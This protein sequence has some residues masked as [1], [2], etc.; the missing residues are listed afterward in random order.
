M[1]KNNTYIFIFLLGAFLNLIAQPKFGEISFIEIDAITSK[2]AISCIVQDEDGII[3]IGTYGSGIYRFDGINYIPYEHDFSDNPSINGNIIHQI[4]IDKNKRLWVGTNSGLNLYNKNLDRFE[5][6]DMKSDFFIPDHF[7]A[8][9][10]IQDSF[11][12]LLVSTYGNGILKIDIETL[13]VTK[14]SST[15]EKL[16]TILVNT[17][18][19]N[20]KGKVLAGTNSGLFEFDNKSNNL[21]RS[22]MNIKGIH[23]HSITI[24]SLLIDNKDNLWIGTHKNG[25]VKMSYTDGVAKGKRFPW[26]N[27]KVFSMITFENQILAGTENDGLLVL[28]QEKG[29]LTQNY[30]HDELNPKSIG[31][32]SIWSLCI[33]DKGRIWLGY[34][35]KGVAVF[36]KNY[37][38]FKSFEGEV[39]NK[40]SI[41]K[42]S[43]SG[44]AKDNRGRLWISLQD[45]L[46]IYDPNTG[47]FHHIR[48]D[49]NKEYT[50]LNGKLNLQRI[51]I[52]SKQN[53]WLA[54]WENGLY[55]LK[56]D[57]KEF[58]NFNIKNTDGIL[59]TN[60]I[61]DFS[62]DSQG[63]IWIASF[64]H[65]IYRYDPITEKLTRCDSEPFITSRLSTSDVLSIMVDQEDNI[66][67]GT[68]SGLFK[69]RYQTQ[70]NDFIVINMSDKMPKEA[71]DH[72]SIHRISFLYQSEDGTIWVGTKA[73][74][75][76]M[77][78]KEDNAFYLCK[79]LFE[80]EETSINGIIEDNYGSIWISGKL[81]ITK[82]D[83]NN[84]TSV[85]FTE[86]DGLLT[87]YFNDGAI[88]KDRNGLLYFGNFS[89]IN[90]IDPGNMF[91]NEYTPELYFTNFKLFNKTVTVNDE[92][93]ILEKVIS[94]TNSIDLAYNQ[95]VF[96]IEY[97]G[98]TFTRPERNQYAYILEG[99]D[100]DWNYV[101]NARNATYTNLTPGE[102]VF[103]LKGA[104]NDGIWNAKTLN[105]KIHVLP[106]WWRSN[107][108]YVFYV[109]TFLCLV[110]VITWIIRNRIKEKQITL[111]ERERRLQEEKLNKAKLQFFTNISHEFRTP[112][113]LIMNPISDIVNRSDLALPDT[114]RQKHNIIFKNSQ[115]LSRLINELMDFRKLESN[116]IY[117][118]AQQF[119]V[120]SH[121]N[122]VLAFFKEEALCRDISLSFKTNKK[123]LMVWADPNMLEKILFNILSNAFKVTPEKGEIKV[124]LK[125]KKSL[126]ENPVSMKKE[127]IDTFQISIKDNGPG[128]DQKEYKRIFK[129]FYQVSILNKDYYG[130]SGIGLE[131]VKGFVELH[132]GLIDV[133]SELEKGTEFTITLLMGKEHFLENEIFNEENEI[134]SIPK[135]QKITTHIQ[136]NIGDNLDTS[137]KKT[138]TVLI[139]DDNSELLNYL[140][141]E[142]LPY[143]N[144]ITATNGKKGFEIA[145][146]KSPHLIITDVIMP[147]MGGLEMCAQIKKDITTSHIPLLML[148]ARAIAEDQIK[149][150]DSGADAYLNKP[151]NIDVLKATLSGLLTNR[152]ILF[153]KYS[154]NGKII[155][156]EN[157]TTID[158]EFIKKVLHYIHQ[159]LEEP[160]L[161]VEVLASHLF[162]SRSQLYRKI[163][164]LTGL[165]V[166][167]FI[168]KVRLEEAKK[169]ISGKENYN[170]NEIAFKVGFS[171]SSY[172]SKC[173]KKE[174]GHSP[175]K[176]N[177]SIKP[178]KNSL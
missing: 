13:F 5:E 119:D 127:V 50:G 3:W 156:Q 141:C 17:F 67:A 73:A 120:V 26:T 155:P 60:S 30:Q 175:K 34:Y 24:E 137:P 112:L 96:S 108:A 63:R 176:S 166:N 23:D 151:F 9:N 142:L 111:L 109:M 122:E 1:V 167:E 110:Y 77:Y 49:E 95:S 114:I 115:R 84:K 88:E 81:G 71:N 125:E 134:S 135:E 106:P 136:N 128:I 153:D 102:Y 65:G 163:K 69:I 7:N 92:N 45:G 56:K 40:N 117:I 11:G 52:D 36:D 18:A 89:G 59:A 14:V 104:N 28:D 177:A 174:F 116:K 152:R 86:G 148:T 131:M 2:D 6:L 75:L 171:S 39:N 54:T 105:L 126:K 27:K 168:R 76:Q 83:R 44:I 164:A 79:D 90:Y 160:D 42:Y 97:M 130:S 99:F 29:T 33:D 157:S 87:N 158:N 51:F 129:R 61:R 98:T 94:R 70:E 165:S 150:I 103:K 113:T 100:A 21:K 31:S 68:S 173:F 133:K 48:S 43:V 64:L 91:L 147:I 93:K 16:D 20:K 8:T 58:I 74:G 22:L 161:S 25:I 35:N 80:L 162:L 47:Q 4:Y 10:I 149:G 143:Y 145:K 53:I 78:D 12:N 19:I 32:N 38:K 140:S 132:R 41:Q 15:S 121:I 139:V 62:E 46:D 57:S 72:P 107:T 159:K 123:T 101:G 169:L 37:A 124:H 66:W 170:V 55:L 138:Y 85:R 172:F 82:I 146:E 118:K 144:V 154:N 178:Q